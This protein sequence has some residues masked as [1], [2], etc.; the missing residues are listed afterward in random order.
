MEE[1]WS[2]QTRDTLTAIRPGRGH[3]WV[4][5]TSSSGSDTDG[6]ADTACQMD[7]TVDEQVRTTG[8]CSN[9]ANSY[10]L[11]VR[12]TQIPKEKSTAHSEH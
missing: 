5:I 6:V 1:N 4:S 2:G 9:G 11:P 8:N 12:L 10:S 3:A 7:G